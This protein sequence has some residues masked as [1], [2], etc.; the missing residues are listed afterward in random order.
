MVISHACGDAALK[1]T[2]RTIKDIVFF[3]SSPKRTLV[4][5]K[6][7]AAIL[8]SSRHTR[9]QSLCETRRVER[10]EAIMTFAELYPAVV[11]SLELIASDMSF[12]NE[13]SDKTDGF[14]LRVRTLDFVCNLKIL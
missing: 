7:I 1:K 14:K 3:T 9:L 8:P 10:H 5:K 12:N 13:V 4:L 11:H 2:N 6:A